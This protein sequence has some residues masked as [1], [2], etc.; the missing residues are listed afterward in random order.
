MGSTLKVIEFVTPKNKY[1]IFYYKIPVSFGSPYV[2]LQ[3]QT[4][5]YRR[6]VYKLSSKE[7]PSFPLIFNFLTLLFFFMYPLSR[8]IRLYT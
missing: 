5:V 6:T 7:A 8:I 1:S 4:H 2:H 3:V